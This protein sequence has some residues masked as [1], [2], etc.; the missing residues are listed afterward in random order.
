M[1][2]LSSLNLSWDLSDPSWQPLCL[3]KPIPRPTHINPEDGG[4]MLLKNSDIL[5]VPTQ[6][7]ISKQLLWVPEPEILHLHELNLTLNIFTLDH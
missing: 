7:T 2:G 4:N 3:T 6:N 1:P 5:S